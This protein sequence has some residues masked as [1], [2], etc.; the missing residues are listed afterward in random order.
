[1]R[2]RGIFRGN[3]PQ[4]KRESGQKAGNTPPEDQSQP[5]VGPE[6]SKPSQWTPPPP[7]TESHTSCPATPQTQIYIYFCR[8]WSPKFPRKHRTPPK[9]SLF[10]PVF[11]ENLPRLSEN[12]PQVE[13]ERSSRGAAGEQPG[14]IQKETPPPA[15]ERQECL[16]PIIF[17]TK[18]TAKSHLAL[19]EKNF[20]KNLWENV[21]GERKAPNLD[22]RGRGAKIRKIDFV[23]K[24]S[25]II[26]E[27]KMRVLS[28]CFRTIE[29]CL[30]LVGRC[31]YVLLAFGT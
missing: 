19:V 4:A 23:G 26:R 10:L 9:N 5:Q 28:F 29:P 22:E 13:Q 8:F 12:L 20:G 17:R 21:S 2:N 18:N 16:A 11:A 3:V 24:D 25:V 30:C 6:A 1:M 27:C 31:L 14:S 15:G 7:P